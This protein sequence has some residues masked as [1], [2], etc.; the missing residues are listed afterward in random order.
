MTTS[1]TPDERDDYAFSEMM[2]GWNEA[3][4]ERT[5]HII[6]LDQPGGHPLPSLSASMVFLGDES[7]TDRGAYHRA[8]AIAYDLVRLSYWNGRTPLRV[9]DAYAIHAGR[10]VTLSYDASYGEWI[11]RRAAA[12]KSEA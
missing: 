8:I 2:R 3:E 5:A 9:I 11:V 12:P 10:C 6:D 4:E 1:M 7:V